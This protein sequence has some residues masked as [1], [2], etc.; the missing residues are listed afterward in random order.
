MKPMLSNKKLRIVLAWSALVIGAVLL[1]FVTPLSLLPGYTV[2]GTLFGLLGL[3]F[4][5]IPLLAGIRVQTA[6]LML[7]GVGVIT[8]GVYGLTCRG[9]GLFKHRE[10]VSMNGILT[11]E[12]AVA[13][14]RGTGLEGW[15]LAAHAQKL[16]AH[17]ISYARINPWD[18][19]GTSFRQGQG[20]CMQQAQALEQ[21]Y[22]ALGIPCRLV[23]ADQ[24][25][26]WSKDLTHSVVIS[27]AWLKVT[28]NSEERDVCPGDINNFPGF[29]NFDVLSAPRTLKPAFRPLAHIAFVLGNITRDP[30]SN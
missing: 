20:Y 7:L 30:R 17:K 29:T 15:E 19:P 14:C 23:Y 22:R 6:G 3:I 10:G 18:S 13:A 21:I 28:L 5:I 4:I 24:C 27:H 25:R 26:F 16:V 1:A 12:E 11:V 2:M 8:F 9:V